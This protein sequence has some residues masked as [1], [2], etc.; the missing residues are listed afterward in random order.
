LPSILEDLSF[1]LYVS[2]H[3]LR[4]Q[5]EQKNRYYASVKKFTSK[6]YSYRNCSI[7]Q[8]ITEYNKFL[9][10]EIKKSH[11]FLNNKIEANYRRN[12]HEG[13]VS[14]VTSLVFYLYFKTDKT[15]RF[16]AKLLAAAYR[17]PYTD[18]QTRLI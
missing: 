5:Q 15:K 10:Y 13:E 6:Y 18:K 12:Y 3:R 11:F 8:F 4:Y 16:F 2:E 7:E 1:N 17:N 9:N 14:P